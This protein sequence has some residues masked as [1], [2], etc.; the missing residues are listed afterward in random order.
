M[1][2]TRDERVGGGWCGVVVGMKLREREEG[3]VE[4]AIPVKG[5]WTPKGGK[6]ACGSSLNFL[7]GCFLASRE[8]VH[9][10]ES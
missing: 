2:E 1:G 8:I 5:R 7:I 4:E 9:S 10:R 6:S 3:K